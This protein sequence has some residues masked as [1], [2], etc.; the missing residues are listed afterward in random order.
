MLSLAVVGIAMG[1]YFWR[2]TGSPFRMPTRVN[3]DPMR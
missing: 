2:V 1:F 3:R